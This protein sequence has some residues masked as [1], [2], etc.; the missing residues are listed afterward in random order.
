[1][2]C[3]DLKRWLNEGMPRGSERDVGEHAE[4]CPGCAA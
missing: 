1:M 2:N 3:A 4:R